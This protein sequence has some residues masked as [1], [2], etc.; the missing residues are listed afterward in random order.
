M[1]AEWIDESAPG[2]NGSGPSRSS[3]G[4]ASRPPRRGIIPTDEGDQN[5]HGAHARIEL[6]GREPVFDHASSHVLVDGHPLDGGPIGGPTPDHLSLPWRVRLRLE[7]IGPW[8]AAKLA[9]LFGALVMAA[10]VAGLVFLYSFLGAAGVLHAIQRLVNQSGVGHHFQFNGG[11][12]LIRV[13]WVAAG[14]VIAGAVIGFCLAAL[15]NSL[16]DLTGGLDVTFVERVKHQEPLS[17]TPA[18]TSRSGMTRA[19]RQ[20]G[21]EPSVDRDDLPKAAGL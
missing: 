7:H 3:P 13:I 16:A 14:L 21:S 5:G 19:W 18:W 20:D 1:S 11:W 17:S 9:L 12:L 8:S 4:R 10:V 2:T 15:Y 6:D